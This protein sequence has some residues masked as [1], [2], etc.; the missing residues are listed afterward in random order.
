[1]FRVCHAFL[2]VLCNLVVTCWERAGHLTLLCVEFYCGFVTF[3]Y[4]VLGQVCY[5]IVSISDLCLL[6]LDQMAYI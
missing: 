2:S 1:M 4:G 5:L 3:P 6:K